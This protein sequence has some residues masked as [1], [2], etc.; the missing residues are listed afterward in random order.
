MGEP[1]V[2]VVTATYD[3]AE[4][5]ERALESVRQ[6]TIDHRRM[7]HVVVDDASTDGTTECV[8]AFDAP[9]LRLVETERNTGPWR[10]LN[11]G[12]EVARGEYLVVLDADDEFHPTLVERLTAVLDDS[13]DVDFVYCD[14]H[15][16]FPD[17]ERVEVDTGA[18]IM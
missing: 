10:A 5:V 16:Q 8:R 18:D 6:Q 14:Y 4:F 9:Y 11:R 15:E 12:I 2:S 3:A 13:P 1:D 7:E 17:G